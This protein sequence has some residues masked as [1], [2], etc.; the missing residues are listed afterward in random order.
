MEHSQINDEDK[1][2]KGVQEL[3]GRCT[4]VV[5]KKYKSYPKEVQELPERSTR[6]V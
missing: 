1:R 5:Q 4:R 2:W 6:V 3:S